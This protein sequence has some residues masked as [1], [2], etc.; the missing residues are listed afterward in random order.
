MFFISARV[1]RPLAVVYR[2]EQGLET[3]FEGGSRSWRNNNLGNI[4]GGTFAD[5][6]G[7][8]GQDSRFAIFPDEPTGL[9]AVVALLRTPTYSVL[10]LE[11]A[12]NRYAPPHENDTEGYVAFV[13]KRTGLPKSRV[14]L[15][16]SDSDLAAIAGAIK[17]I[18]GWREGTIRSADSNPAV[19]GGPAAPVSSAAPAAQD[20]MDIARAEAARPAQDRSEWAGSATNPR[21]VEYFKVAAPWFL[22]EVK[23]GGDEVDW[24]A[25]FVNFCL[26]TAGFPGTGHPGARSFFWPNQHFVRIPDAQPGCIAVYR[27]APFSNSEWKTGTGH[28]GFVVDATATTVTLLGGNQSNTVREQT[29]PREFTSNGKVTRR[30]A[31]FVMP[32]MH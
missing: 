4:V 27:D 15:E 12:I 2:D 28:V 7:A 11:G 32:A 24:C 10:S 13:T 26:E 22:P 23:K 9:K 16:M 3:I 5:A 21:I 31:C 19:T 1:P 20:W 30:I 25:A 18:E 6:H 14:M 29:F 8:I 17:V